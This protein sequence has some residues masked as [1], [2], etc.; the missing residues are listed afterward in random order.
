MY[1]LLLK[2]NAVTGWYHESVLG[3]TRR[4]V[5]SKVVLLTPTWFE[6]KLSLKGKAEVAGVFTASAITYRLT[7]V[8]YADSWQNM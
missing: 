6:R 1:I 5:V 8:P 4:E 2:L 3:S 7:I